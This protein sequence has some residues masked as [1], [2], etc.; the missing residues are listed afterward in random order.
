MALVDAFSSERIVDG[1]IV[2]EPFEIIPSTL[3]DDDPTEVESGEILVPDGDS[4]LVVL[5]S[6]DQ[7]AGTGTPTSVTWQFL[8]SYDGSN[9]FVVD[10]ASADAWSEI[11]V[12]LAA[13]PDNR[14]V[15]KG[16]VV[17]PFFKVK[18]VAADTDAVSTFTVSASIT[19][20][21]QTIQV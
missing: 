8:I 14:A 5:L 2:L 16:R 13:M 4:E 10:G 12:L 20:V 18:A 19:R 1:R 7:G 15:I 17:A 21:P 11:A 9:F 6:A 3:L